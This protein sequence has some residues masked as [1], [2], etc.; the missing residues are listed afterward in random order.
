[1]EPVRLTQYARGGGCACKIPAGE[2]EQIVAGLHG[3]EVPGA[4]VLVGLDDGDDAAAVRIRGGMAV[5][6]TSDFFTP[7]VDDP[8]DWGRIAAANA[9]SDIYAMGGEP[10]MAINLVAWPRELLSTDHLREVLRGGLDVA[11]EADCPVLGGHSIDAPEPIFGMAVTGT[12]DPDRMMRNDAAEPG[13]PISL[14]KPLGVGVLNN[15]HKA[16]GERSE[17]AIASM[18]TLNRDAARAALAAGVR[19]ATDV[20]GFGLLG[21]LYKMGRASGVAA[22]IDAAAVPYISGARE[23]L[24]AGHVP[25]GSKRNLDWVRP[26]LLADGISEDELILLADAQTSGGLLVV[27]E[28]PGAP[29]IGETVA[30]GSLGDGVIVQVS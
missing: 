7:V 5:L 26:H 18:V 14:T 28:V 29:V 10:V 21:H 17:E 6:S 16:T 30:A 19:A 13:L 27:G 12:A 9:I 4:E 8:Y 20:T 23:A 2:L 15:R 3:A 24:A 22:R 25:G 1:M 11:T